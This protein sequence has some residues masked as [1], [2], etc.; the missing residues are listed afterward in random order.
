MSIIGEQR[1]RADRLS[2]AELTEIT[3]TVAA[4][5]EAGLHPVH[6][7]PLQRWHV[8]LRRDESVDVWLISWTTAQGTSLHDHG[9]SSGAFTVV[10][11]ALTETVAAAARTGGRLTE[12]RREAGETVAFGRRY[13]HD[14]E[15]FDE[16][17]AV[18]VHA[19]SPPLES[20]NYYQV[21][22]GRLYRLATSWTDDPEAPAPRVSA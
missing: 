19:Y 4:E 20:M 18:S 12:L 9:G 21:T 22:Q 15:N 11:G 16:A 5:V 14:V 7:D 8:R 13:I 3:R 2:L 6:S 17:T 1:V 10:R